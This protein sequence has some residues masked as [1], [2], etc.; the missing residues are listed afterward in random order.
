MIGRSSK[1]ATN[2]GIGSV[3]GA[4]LG[5]VVLRLA[6]AVW[7][8][9]FPI[10]MRDPAIFTLLVVMLAFRPQGLMGMAEERDGGR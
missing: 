7:S 4:L 1:G 8:A 10:E 2:G 9:L 3:P 5:G 6:E